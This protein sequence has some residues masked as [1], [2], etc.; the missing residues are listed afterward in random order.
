[1]EKNILKFINYCC[2]IDDFVELLLG[3]LEF[4]FYCGFLR[5]VVVSF[6]CFIC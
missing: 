3:F 1:M 5:E 6:V 4:F 2:G